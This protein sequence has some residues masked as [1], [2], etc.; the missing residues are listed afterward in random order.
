MSNNSTDNSGEQTQQS[1]L[2]QQNDEAFITELYNE[3]SQEPQSQP[4]ELLDQRIINAA[5]KAIN[6]SNKPIRKNPINWYS[7][8]ATAASLT[9]VVSLVALQKDNILPNEHAD[10]I[11][12]QDAVVKEPINRTSEI[13]SFIEQEIIAERID[14]QEQP[15]YSSLSGQS[16]G[17]AAKQAK[18]ANSER[19]LRAMQ[20]KNQIQLAK[21]KTATQ[22]TT[23]QAMALSPAGMSLAE[24]EQKHTIMSLSIKQFQ[25]Y[26]L[27]NKTL[28]PKHQWLW[29]LH[30][31][32]DAEYI[33]YI[34]QDKQRLTYRLD[35]TSFKIIG[36]PQNDLK[37]LAL[38]NKI[39][40][41]I[42]ILN[43]NN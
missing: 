11:L 1:T 7:T 3:V 22:K 18:M 35:K 24:R 16:S 40:P 28:S 19:T 42:L 9:L 15:S 33:I 30:L 5:H 32:S 17:T 10:I 29:S 21:Q 20:Y 14:Y 12:K 37:E 43:T 25:Q 23:T 4:S 6:K 38:K 34:A 36:T 41:K 26:T 27:L 8:L 31:E 13:E 2:Q 39:L